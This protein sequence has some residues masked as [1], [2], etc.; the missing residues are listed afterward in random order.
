MFRDGTKKW[1]MKVFIFGTNQSLENNG[2][3]FSSCRNLD[4]NA[5]PIST[6]LRIGIFLFEGRDIH[7]HNRNKVGFFVHLICSKYN[8]PT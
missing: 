8:P 1:P 5:V 7:F 6:I 2:L 4:N 3:S